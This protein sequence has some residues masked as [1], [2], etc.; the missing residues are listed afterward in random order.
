MGKIV[1]DNLLSLKDAAAW[2]TEYL[3]RPVSQTNISYLLQYALIS[4]K[5]LDGLVAVDQKELKEYYDNN[6]KQ[7]QH[8]RDKLGQDLNWMLSFYNLR[9]SDTTKHVHRLHP[10]KGKFI[11]QL[12][13]YFLDSHTDQYKKDVYFNQNDIVLDPFCGSGTTLVQ[14]NE[15]NMNAIGIDVSYFN[16]LISNCKI[17]KID[18]EKLNI[19]CN[20]ITQSIVEYE[21]E[22]HLLDFE[23]ELNHQLSLFNEKYFPRYDFKYQVKT[24]KVIDKI[25]GKEKEKEILPIFNALLKK[26]NIRNIQPDGKSF[27]S[28]WFFPSIIDELYIVLDFINEDKNK[29]VRNMLMLI[30]SRTMRSCRAT[31]HSDLATL[32]EPIVT[33]YYCT[34]HYQICRPL[35]SISKWWKSYSKDT[36]K[37]LQAF[38]NIRSMNTFQICLTGDSRNIDIFDELRKQNKQIYQQV[39]NQKIKGIFSSPPYVGMIDYHEQHAYAYDLFKF[40]R[41]DEKEIGPLYKGQRQE[42]KLSYIEGIS[43]VLINC[44]PYLIEGFN[45]FLVANDKYNLYPEIAKKAG[46]TIVNQYKRPVLNRTEKDKNAYSEIIFH[47]READDEKQI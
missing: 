32:L 35:F 22:N 19:A 40:P 11:P 8:L 6:K 34:K 37:R 10:Y 2:G 33:P 36:L 4:K 17:S 20:E 9:E 43:E 31:T 1:N 38:N 46:L 28:T 29:E 47:M 25:Y 14:A 39:K 27:L 30:L 21:S 18:L 41:E 45:I 24:K 42:A 5:N 13:E 15:L 7:E 3:G 44:K 23:D 12:V 26:Y 16:T